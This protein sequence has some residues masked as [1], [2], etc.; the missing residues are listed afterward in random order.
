MANRFTTF[1]ESWWAYMPKPFKLLSDDLKALEAIVAAGGG[2]ASAAGVTASPLAAAA[3]QQEPRSRE[4]Q[5]APH[6]RHPGPQG[7]C[8]A[9]HP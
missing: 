4:S 1:P 5:T 2:S 6:G 7:R 3:H 8:P 9:A